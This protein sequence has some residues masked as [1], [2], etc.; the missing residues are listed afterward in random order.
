MT[1]ETETPAAPTAWVLFISHR[2]GEDATLYATEDAASAAVAAWARD[3]W[4]D[5]VRGKWRTPTEEWDDPPELDDD[6]VRIYF[7][8]VESEWYWL[9]KRSIVGA[10]VPLVL[11]VRDS[12]SSNDFEV[13]D[14]AAETYD[15]DLGRM[16]LDDRTEFL[17]WAVSH[18]HAAQ[19]FRDEGRV[20][21]AERIEELV[22][23]R[24]WPDD[25]GELPSNE[26]LLRL[27]EEEGVA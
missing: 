23:D 26:T 17:E 21:V 14:G 1:A 6:V 20:A 11:V 18:L 12:D 8:V 9:D 16:D 4:D 25:L 2:H 5:E 24:D 3:W 15:V 7:E 22:A 10:V 19:Q 13:F 27:A